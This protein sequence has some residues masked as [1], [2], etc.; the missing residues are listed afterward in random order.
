MKI[1]LSYASQDS[2]A[3]KSIYFALRDQ[4]HRVF[5][6]RANLPA[7]DEFHNR[8]RAA[9]EASPLFIFLI[10]A[11]AVD[12]GSYTLT[13][14]DIAEKANAKLLP[15]ALGKLAVGQLPAALKAVTF[16]ETDGNLPAAVALAVHRIATDWR[17]RRL[18]RIAATVA[19]IIAVCAALY[20]AINR[21]WK[22][23]LVGKD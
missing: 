11:N 12:A 22:N 14:L 7:G 1:F 21:Q 13:E 8:I 9:I 6:D 17:R 18:K 15:V 16:L 4:G 23:Q 2:E 10:S 3:A 19:G 20:Y 5:Y